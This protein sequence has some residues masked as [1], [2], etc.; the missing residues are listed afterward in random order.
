MVCLRGEN[1]RVDKG[2]QALAAG[3]VGMILANDE[4]NG[5]GVSAD[6]HLLPTSHISYTDGQ[7]VFAYLRSTKYFFFV[8]HLFSQYFG[9][10]SIQYYFPSTY[11]CYVRF[12][13]YKYIYRNPEAFISRVRTQL[14]TKPAPFM[15][16][17]SS[18]GPNLVE[19]SILKVC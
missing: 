11:N 17:F 6:P 9:T 5:N 2:Y 4:S 12:L 13:I 7:R 1:A 18:A 3:A 10:V 14:D 8:F 15:A 16:A 19:P